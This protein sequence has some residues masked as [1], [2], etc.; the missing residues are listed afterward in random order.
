MCDTGTMVKRD[1]EEADDF[2]DENFLA[3]KFDPFWPNK[4]KS[5]STN[6]QEK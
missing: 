4:S 2:N 1:S 3:A 6:I 5:P